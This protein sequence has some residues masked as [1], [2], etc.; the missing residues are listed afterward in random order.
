MIELDYHQIRA[1]QYSTTN[2]YTT[3]HAES[4][5]QVKVIEILVVLRTIITITFLGQ[6]SEHTYSSPS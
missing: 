3:R 1:W 2:T 5:L 4:M 6:E